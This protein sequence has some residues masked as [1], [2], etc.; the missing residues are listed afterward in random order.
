VILNIDAEPYQRDEVYA[1]GMVQKILD[2]AEDVRAVEPALPALNAPGSWD[3]FMSHAQATG[4][5]LVQSTSLR[6]KS[7]GQ[8]VWYDN[9]MKDKST[10]AMEEGV[11]YSRCFVLF[12]TGTVP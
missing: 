3:L 8:A 12:L 1:Q 9:A 2:K 11:K 4:G 10:A 6:L 7:A 5:D